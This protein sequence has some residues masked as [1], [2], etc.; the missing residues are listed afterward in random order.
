MHEKLANSTHIKFN[1]NSREVGVNIVKRLNFAHFDD[2][3]DH[4]SCP[5]KDFKDTYKGIILMELEPLAPM[6]FD[7][8]AA[9]RIYKVDDQ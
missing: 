8:E 6:R 2:M 4:V 7:R 1:K 9:T 5:C 3:V